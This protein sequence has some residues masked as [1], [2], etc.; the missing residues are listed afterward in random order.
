[1]KKIL[2]LLLVML[3]ALSLSAC[4]KKQMIR[5]FSA[6]PWNAPM[7]PIT[8]HSLMIQTVQSK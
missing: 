8:G 5:R 2:A 6:L 1:M 4:S 7:L 3:M